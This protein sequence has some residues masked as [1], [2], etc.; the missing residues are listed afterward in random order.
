MVDW[1]DP[2][3]R[4][5]ALRDAYFALISGGAVTMIKTAAGGGEREVRYSKA[6]LATVRSEMQTAE[7]ECRT[8]NGQPPVQRRFAIRAGSR[9]F[10]FNRSR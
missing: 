5:V 8:K 7:D 4:A 1:T 9:G 2:C 3:A 6:D 10:G